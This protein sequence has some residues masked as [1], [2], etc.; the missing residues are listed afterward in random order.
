LGQLTSTKGLAVTAADFS[1]REL[2]HSIQFLR[3]KLQADQT[4]V[5][6]QYPGYIAFEEHEPGYFP[7]LFDTQFDTQ[8]HLHRLPMA[9]I[10]EQ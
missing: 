2:H 5:P 1:G 10:S 7:A 8:I 6:N 9:Y 3:L 4:I